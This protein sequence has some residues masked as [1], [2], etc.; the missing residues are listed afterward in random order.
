MA[1][2]A[3]PG[4]L[5]GSRPLGESRPLG[6]SRPLARIE[7]YTRL[8]D[9]LGQGKS[10]LALSGLS[11]V[12]RAFLAAALRQDTGRPQGMPGDGLAG[13]AGD[14]RPEDGRHRKV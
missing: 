10:P 3:L 5:G 4:L 14:I 13:G 1:I 6:G 7:E 2:S 12:H 9:A 11:A 8:T